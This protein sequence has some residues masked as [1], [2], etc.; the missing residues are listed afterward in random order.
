M[1]RKPRKQSY[2]DHYGFNAATVLSS[3]AKVGNAG[4][5]GDQARIDAE[6]ARHRQLMD[7]L[8]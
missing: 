5:S 2:A 6:R 4:R 3:I 8:P 1:I 7:A